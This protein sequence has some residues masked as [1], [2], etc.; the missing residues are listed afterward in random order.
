MIEVCVFCH[1][2]GPGKHAFSRDTLC[3]PHLVLSGIPAYEAS[4]PLVDGS[5][6]CTPTC[7]CT[8]LEEMTRRLARR[9]AAE[10]RQEET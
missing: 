9:R 3:P 6:P 8:T 2:P 5:R 4:H 1:P 7:G 10:Q